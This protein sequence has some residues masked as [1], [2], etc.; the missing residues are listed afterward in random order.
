MDRVYVIAQNAFSFHDLM[1]WC[2]R[3]WTVQTEPSGRLKISD[4]DRRLYLDVDDGLLDRYEK[5]VRRSIERAMPSARCYVVEY[6]PD[7]LDF[8]KQV[9]VQFVN[10]PRVFVDTQSG[11]ILPGT[12]F[13]QRL[14]DDFDWDWREG[15]A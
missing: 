7:D 8:L 10:D 14:K 4:G 1:L 11:L 5:E 15:S 13:V 9:L 2:R 12:D 3:R 6:E